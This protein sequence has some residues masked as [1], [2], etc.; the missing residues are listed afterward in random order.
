MSNFPG[1]TPS[2]PGFTAGHTLLVDVHASQHN[3]EQGEII[4]LANKMGT[5]A[6]TPTSG[7]VLRGN[8]T[9][10]STWGQVVLT[11][12]VTGVLPIANGGTG[13]TSTT[14]TGSVVFGTSPTIAS[15]TLTTPTIASFTNATHNH[16]N[17]AGGGTLGAAA[18]PA[19]DL[20]IQTISNPYKFR[21]Y[22]N[23]A[24]NTGNG[25]FATVAFD[26]ESYDTNNNHSAGTY[27]A[28]IT[29]YYWF[30]GGISVG[31]D[32]VDTAVGLFKNGTEFARGGQG[33]FGAVSASYT[34][35]DL[36]PLTA[37]DTVTLAAFAASTKALNVGASSQNYLS[38]FLVST[39]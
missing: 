11:T 23:A 24:A 33:T 36:I 3:L 14:G 25:A 4:A 13:T 21:A 28:P 34:V 30:A 35:S 10:T 38:G 39:T 17:A 18:V 19:L 8:G 7:M 37:G 2:F 32:N 27:T 1:S 6:S 29:G 5:G 22:R 20:S 15:P 16:L 9:G 26:T 31:S 12:D